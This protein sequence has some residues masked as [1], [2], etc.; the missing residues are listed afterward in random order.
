MNKFH[1]MY[2]NEKAKATEHQ[3]GLWILRGVSDR[4]GRCTVKIWMPKAIKPYCHYAFLSAEDREVYIQNQI[5]AMESLNQQKEARKQLKQI[6]ANMLESITP[7]TIFHYSWGYDQTNC[8]FWEVIERKGQFVTIREIAQNSKEDGFMSGHTSPIKG[9]FLE[10][11]TPIRKKIQT[12]N[13]GKS[14]YLKMTS[15]GS[16]FLWDGSSCYYSYYA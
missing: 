13:S 1:A 2:L 12:Y 10:N 11:S 16:A 6:P 15:Y 7:G 8:E 9:K 14:I 5:K 4:T 3:A